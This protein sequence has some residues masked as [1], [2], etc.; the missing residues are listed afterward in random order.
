MGVEAPEGQSGLLRAL[1]SPPSSFCPSPGGVGWTAGPCPPASLH[2]TFTAS[3]PV[4]L[5]GLSKPFPLSL[6]RYPWPPGLPPDL[7]STL[8]RQ[9]SC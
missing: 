1:P 5:S 7:L 9:T 4:L 2:V 8:P 6:N 3:S